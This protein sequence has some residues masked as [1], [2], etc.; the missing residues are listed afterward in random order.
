MR[1][2]DGGFRYSWE[3]RSEVLRG[4]GLVVRAVSRDAILS[5]DEIEEEEI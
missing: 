1:E 4:V 2:A 5:V 3:G